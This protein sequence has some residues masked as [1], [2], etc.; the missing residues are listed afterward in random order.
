MFDWITLAERA[1][2]KATAAWGSAVDNIV[3]LHN[4]T[5]EMQMTQVTRYRSLCAWCM[6]QYHEEKNKTIKIDNHVEFINS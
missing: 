2:A 4:D 5:F 3:P 6:Q 1:L